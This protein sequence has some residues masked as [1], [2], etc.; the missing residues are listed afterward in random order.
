MGLIE[1]L[2]MRLLLW[3][4]LPIGLAVV[5]IGPARVK[6]WFKRG[7]RWLWDK[8]LDPEQIFTS[9]DA[10]KDGKLTKDEL[11]D[12]LRERVGLADA[13]GDGGISKQEL[14]N[15]LKLFSGARGGRGPGRQGSRDAERSE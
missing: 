15:I 2:V 5:L 4:V 10:N 7:W 1:F 9:L 6:S 3:V 8:R 14:E 11:P 13:D 12:P